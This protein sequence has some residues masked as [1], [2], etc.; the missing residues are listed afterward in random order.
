VPLQT[1]ELY[2]TGFGTVSNIFMKK[3]IALIS[4]LS[5]SSSTFA[6]LPQ[7]ENIKNYHCP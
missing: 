6:L 2:L 5:I 3:L 7:C 1:W 4:F